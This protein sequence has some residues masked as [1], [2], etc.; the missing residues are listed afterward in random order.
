MKLE[1]NEYTTESFISMLTKKYGK[2]VSGK[3][4][5]GSDIAQY[6]MRGMTPYRYGALSI[7]SKR[8]G[9]MRI[10]VVNK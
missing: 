6:L 7:D 1:A 4:F 2:K 9:G 8:V 10:I 5:N 3:D